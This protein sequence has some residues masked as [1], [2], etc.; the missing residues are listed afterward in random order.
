MFA[1]TCNSYFPVEIKDSSIKTIRYALNFLL[2]VNQSI[3][4]VSSSKVRKE[5]A[6]RDIEK[7]EEAIST[8]EFILKELE[9]K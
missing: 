2:S 3:E 5:V 4:K 9:C 7:C 6:I 1:Q 8:F